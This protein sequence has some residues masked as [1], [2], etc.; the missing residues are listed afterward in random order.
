MIKI[1]ID[2]IINS[3]ENPFL[4]GDKKGNKFDSIELKQEF[5]DIATK[6]DV[7][8]SEISVNDR[9]KKERAKYNK[10]DSKKLIELKKIFFS[11]LYNSWICFCTYCGKDR[12]THFEENT[13]VFKR[14][15]DI[16]HFLPRS[17]YPDLSVNLYNWLPVCISCNQR[18]KKAK[19]PLDLKSWE[20]I[21]HPYFGFLE[22]NIS[23]EIIQVDESFD[24][25]YSFWGNHEI[26]WEGE[27][28]WKKK[29]IIYN[30]KHSQFF[31]LG[32][33]YFNSQDT[34]ENFAF[35]QE[36]RTK[37]LEEKQRFKNCSKSNQELKDY[38]FKNYA[39]QSENEILKF[40]NGKF[41][42]DL[43]DNLKLEQ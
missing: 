17:L 33:I 27:E 2:E 6:W 28:E 29:E 30:S 31:E 9:D 41:K 26:Q 3:L 1:E 34:A 10:Y 13:W 4:T 14:L 15:Y 35:I 39:P 8:F 43:I 24:E 38:F 32:K 19:N 25:K 37:I 11:K 16:E 18:L 23:W 21:F 22:K 40:S 42:K 20:K 36:Q 12:L 7:S 5:L